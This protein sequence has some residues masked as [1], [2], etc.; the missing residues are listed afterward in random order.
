MLEIGPELC[1]VGMADKCFING[2]PSQPSLKV[3]NLVFHFPI[4]SS[5]AVFRYFE[6]VT[7]TLCPIILQ[8]Y[9]SNVMKNLLG[10]PALQLLESH[11]AHGKKGLMRSC[12]VSLLCSAHR[13]YLINVTSHCC[14]SVCSSYRGR[15]KNLSH[16]I[17][18]ELSLKHNINF[19][20]VKCE[21]HYLVFIR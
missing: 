14:E 11:G 1:A 3:F 9:V 13:W 21:D 20:L 4:P 2:L 5:G 19:I 10:E 8:P 6:T 15:H 16:H 7:L 17:G 12:K 18:Q